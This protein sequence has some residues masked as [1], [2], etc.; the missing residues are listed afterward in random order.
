[1]CW[2]LFSHSVIPLF[3]MTEGLSLQAFVSSKGNKKKKGTKHQ[4]IKSVTESGDDVTEL[5][6][7]KDTDGRQKDF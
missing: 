2:T 1:M 5:P 3:P 6:L 7:K 4:H